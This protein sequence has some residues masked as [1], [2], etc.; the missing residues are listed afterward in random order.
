MIVD[1][2]LNEKILKPICITRYTNNH[3][4][5]S[6]SEMA[7][8]LGVPCITIVYWLGEHLGYPD[9]LLHKR[10]ELIKFYDYSGPPIN[11]LGL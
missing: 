1:I 10:N 7:E 2:S 6:L 8:G 4:T 11:A 9:E 3:R 5:I